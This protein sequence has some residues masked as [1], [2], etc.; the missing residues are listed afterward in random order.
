LNY[1]HVLLKTKTNG[2]IYHYLEIVKLPLFLPLKAQ[3]A[4]IYSKTMTPTVIHHHLKILQEKRIH[5]CLQ[6]SKDNKI[7]QQ[8][9]SSKM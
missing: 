4:I 9:I 3:F 2:S 8:L 5:T 1:Q 7:A 6:W